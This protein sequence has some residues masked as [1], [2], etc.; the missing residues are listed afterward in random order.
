MRLTLVLSLEVI[1]DAV[2]RH[3]VSQVDV[4]VQ[5]VNQMHDFTAF[6]NC[7]TRNN[8][9]KTLRSI[10]TG[11][12]NAMAG[13]QAGDDERIDAEGRQYLVEVGAFEA[14]GI[15]LQ[16]ELFIRSPFEPR[17][18]S[19]SEAFAWLTSETT[20]LGCNPGISCG[21]QS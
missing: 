8:Y 20:L 6:T 10:T 19:Y 9:T 18:K 17:V 11:C 15:P 1:D 7:F 14:G 21:S 4:D 12:I 5:Q 2:R 16:E 13:T 3:H